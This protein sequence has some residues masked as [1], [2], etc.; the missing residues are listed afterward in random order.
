LTFTQAEVNGSPALLCWDEGNLAGV[1][2]LTL[3]AGGI[4]EIYALLNPEKLA[5]LQIQLSGR[6]MITTC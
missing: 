2:S 3:S 5:Y 6:G 1:I 4:Q